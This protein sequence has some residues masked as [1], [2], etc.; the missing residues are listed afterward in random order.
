MSNVTL[1]EIANACAREFG[2]TLDGMRRRYPNSGHREIAAVTAR[3]T[4]MWLA[5]MHTPHASAEIYAFFG[6]RHGNYAGECVRKIQERHW[7]D[8][9]FAK[10]VARIE[11][12]IDRIHEARVDRMLEGDEGRAAA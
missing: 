6:M 7:L 9:G 12:E 8:F 4:G 5:K 11:E 1:S 2:V 10:C 3:N